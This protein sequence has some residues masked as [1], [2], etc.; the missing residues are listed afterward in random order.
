MAGHVG[1]PVYRVLFTPRPLGDA[2]P[3]QGVILR[4]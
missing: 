1:R 4:V 3:A 2:E